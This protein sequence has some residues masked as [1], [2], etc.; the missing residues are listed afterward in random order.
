[1][2]LQNEERKS[3]AYYYYTAYVLFQVQDGKMLKKEVDNASE[4]NNGKCVY[5]LSNDM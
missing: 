1:M 5:A 3:F 2:N 4:N